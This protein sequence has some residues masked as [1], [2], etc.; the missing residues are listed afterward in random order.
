MWDSKSLGWVENLI[1]FV[2]H[3]NFWNLSLFL[4]FSFLS[5]AVVLFLPLGNAILQI[6]ESRVGDK[7]AM[8]FVRKQKARL[9][10]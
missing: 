2:I 5:A 6:L 4:S 3:I 8:D 10:S 7:Q 1:N 9:A